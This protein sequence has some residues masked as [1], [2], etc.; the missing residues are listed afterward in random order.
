[1][2]KGAPGFELFLPDEGNGIATY[3]RDNHDGTV[4]YLTQQD[5]TGILEENVKLQRD[6]KG[7]LARKGKWGAH[8]ATI[9]IGLLYHW[10][11]TEGWDPF[12]PDPENQKKLRQKLNDPEFQKL[13][14][15]RFRM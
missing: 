15:D 2:T 13:R 7:S 14:I 6:A 4:D 10:K 11:A 12:S 9:P 5:P 1:M 3:R 8:A